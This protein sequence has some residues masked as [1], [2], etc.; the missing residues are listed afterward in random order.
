MTMKNLLALAGVSIALTGAAN[1]QP[2]PANWPTFGGDA[3]RTGWE[4]ADARITKDTVK[5]LQLLW[6]M[7]L[8]SQPKGPRP[9]QPP[10]ILGNLISYRGFKELA[11]V[12]SSS[13]IVYAIDADLGKMFWTKHLEYASLDPQLPGS[14]ATCPGGLTAMPSMPPPAA[15]GRGG[16]APA[17]G[18]GAAAS[19]AA[20][21]PSPARRP[22]AAVGAA[23]V[24]A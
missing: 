22:F 6:K 8:E 14:S 4:R 11:F 5:D 9:L 1:A 24:Y 18:R 20:P 16:P 19:G 21:A 13:D 2:R 3:Q 7:K 10:L 17:G 12:A 15:G 23:S